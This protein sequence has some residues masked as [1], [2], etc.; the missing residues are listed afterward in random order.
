MNNVLIH[1]GV[2]GMKWGVR[3]QYEGTGGGG[4]GGWGPN[5]IAGGGGPSPLA[6]SMAGNPKKKKKV[7]KNA[8]KKM[9]IKD[10][11]AVSEERDLSEIQNKSKKLLSSKNLSY[12]SR[13][14]LRKE[15]FTDEKIRKD[16]DEIHETGKQLD[17][18]FNDTI[19]ETSPFAKKAYSDYLKSGGDDDGGYGFFH[20]EWKSGNKY[21][22][23]ANKLYKTRTKELENKY[24]DQVSSLGEK[25]T[26]DLS[27]K[28]RDKEFNETYQ[29]AMEFEIDQVSRH[30]YDEWFID[31]K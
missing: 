24:V 19:S 25:M 6:A 5:T 12:E 15:I 16:L 9:G 27:H 17:S 4:G 31:K 20:Y 29:D 21:Y 30:R 13:K 7:G 23:E 1:Y 10:N 8:V 18:V 3:K 22:D 28:I 14:A 26:G 11:Q 2:K